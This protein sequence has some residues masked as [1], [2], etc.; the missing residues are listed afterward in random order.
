MRLMLGKPL[1]A[2]LI[3][4]MRNRQIPKDE[5]LLGKMAVAVSVTIQADLT[6]PDP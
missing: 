4:R 2:V 5:D 3:S 6:N 1:P